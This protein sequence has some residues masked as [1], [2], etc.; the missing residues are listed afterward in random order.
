MTKRKPL[1]RLIGAFKTVSTKR[2]NDLRDT[3][4]AMLWQRNFYERVLRDD[5][6][7]HRTREYIADSPSRWG[8]NQ[9]NHA[10]YPESS[11]LSYRPN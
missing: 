1:G 6:S 11:D 8:A 4:G 10:T 3:P 2:I 5:S 7:L 9:K